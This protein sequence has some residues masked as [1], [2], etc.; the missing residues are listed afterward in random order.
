MRG[1]SERQ[2]DLITLINV[3]DRI[4]AQH[5]IRRIQRMVDAVLRRLDGEFAT[6]YAP[7]GRASIPPER[8]LKA[9][10]LQAL[11]TVRSDR[12]RRRGTNGCAM[13]C[14]SSGSST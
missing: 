1:R 2:S 6:M 3:E 7:L 9:K 8:L 11:Y 4:P 5:P 14:S 12:S 13:I 10:V